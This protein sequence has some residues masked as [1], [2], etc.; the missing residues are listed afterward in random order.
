MALIADWLVWLSAE[1]RL[2]PKT[3][4]AYERDVRQF[5]YFLRD[6]LG[7]RP[8]LADLEGLGPSDTRAFLAS[9]RSDGTGAR[10]I[11]RQIAGL[12]SLVRFAEKARG[13]ELKVLTGVRG[14]KK[15]QSLP[16]PLDRMS[17]REVI[18]PDTLPATEE[19]WI[20]A[21]DAAVLTLLYAGGLRISEALGLTRGQAPLPGEG[22][23]LRVTGKGGKVRLVPVLDVV[24]TRIADYLRLCPY[25]LP[26]DGPLFVGARGG[27]LNPRLIQ[28]RM[29]QLR[30]A[31]GLPS[32]ATPHALRHSFATHLLSNG[33]DLRSIQELLGHASLS[34]TQ[35]YTEVDEA[36]L[37]EVYRDAHPRA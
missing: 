6:H 30:S 24:R 14:P 21:R 11:S 33:G 15:P 18:E 20:I 5:V 32:S 34:T 3:V 37:L 28:K 1:R 10:S 7:T 8:G 4:E 13:L 25:R 23:S 26:L 27:P 22:D 29:E 19:P 16:K 17:A 35:V 12:K 9:R 36:R 31:L 2:S